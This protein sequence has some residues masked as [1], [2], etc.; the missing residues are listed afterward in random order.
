MSSRCRF[1]VLATAGILALASLAGPAAAKGL[2][3]LNLVS[4]QAG[5]ALRTDPLLVNAWGIAFNGAGTIL[6]VND[7]GT[8]VSTLYDRFGAPLPLVVT[9]PPPQGETGTAAPTGIVFNPTDQFVITQNQKSGRSLFLFDTE[10]G[11]IS[12]WNPQVNATEAVLAVDRSAT[13]A[14]YKGLALAQSGGSPFVYATNFHSGFVEMFDAQFGMVGQFTDPAIT[15][16]GYGPFGIRNVN[17]LLFVTYA[18]QKPGKHDDQAG[19]GN[20]FV[21]V[22]EPDG[23]LLGVFAQHGVLNSPWGMVV[24][25]NG[26]GRFGGTLFV[27]NFGDGT[28]NAFD[29]R[30]GRFVGQLEDRMGRTLAIEG[31]W[32]L[33]K[34]PAFTTGIRSIYFSAGP[35]EETDG[36]LG[37]L[38]LAPAWGRIGGRQGIFSR[39]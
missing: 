4:D 2:V 33:E 35:N 14:V 3:Q 21:V 23:D 31:L 22:F 7:N 9:I 25:P 19:P 30:S 32:G 6:W 39:R 16:Q 37:T 26:L 34:N 18:K 38:R 17:G 1:I 12:G 24:A 36:L 8:G 27:G 28:I 10:D 13:G 20:G 5:M 29:L 15:D 11:T